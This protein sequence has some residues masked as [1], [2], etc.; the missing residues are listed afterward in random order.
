[1]NDW[2]RAFESYMLWFGY[3][4]S[5]KKAHVTRPGPHLVLLF[6]GDWLMRMLTSSLG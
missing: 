5:P 6:R 3:E 4:L 2:E 1:V